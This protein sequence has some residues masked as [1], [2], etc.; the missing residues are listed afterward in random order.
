[1]VDIPSH[2][3]N[4]RFTFNLIFETFGCQKLVFLSIYML[5]K[6]YLSMFINLYW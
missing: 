1:M 5:Y 3:A 6:R 2:H 4:N